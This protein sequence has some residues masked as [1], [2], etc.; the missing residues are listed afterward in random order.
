[1]AWELAGRSSGGQ[2]CG[3]PA[4]SPS[5]ERPS[6]SPAESRGLGLVLARQLVDAGARVVICARTE[7]QLQAAEQELRDRGGAV[8]ALRCDVRDRD[9]VEA[10]VEQVVSRWGDVD[11]LINNAGIIEVG[12]L[13]TMTVEDFQRSMDT[14]CWGALHTVLA[15]LPGMRRRG[16]DGSLTSPRW[17]ASAPCRTCC[18]TRRASSRSSGFPTVCAT[19]LAR[20]N[21]LVTTIC[22]ALMRT[23]SPRNA[24]FKGQHRKEYAWFSIGDSLPMVSMDATVAAR[25]ILLACQHGEGEVVIAGAGGPAIWL[26]TLAPNLV[27]E[28]LALVNLLLP[29]MGGIGQRAARGYE[30]ESNLSPSWLTT[31][32]DQAALRNNEFTRAE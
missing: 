31:L 8:L 21:I 11:V 1:M 25:K 12:P 7:S 15:V 30:S 24:T 9:Q 10:M 29:E 26:Q 13:D 20:E 22:P 28:F 32:G 17:G 23:G 5:R 16:W 18:R 2:C 19:E 27:S 3:I 6:S 14:H 4:G